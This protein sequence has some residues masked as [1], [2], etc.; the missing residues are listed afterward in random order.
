MLFRLHRCGPVAFK[1]VTS[2]SAMLC[3]LHRCGSVAF[4]SNRIVIFPSQSCHS[5]MLRMAKKLKLLLPS[6]TSIPTCLLRSIHASGTMERCSETGSEEAQP[7][8]AV[9]PPPP[10]AARKAGVV[11]GC[12]LRLQ[13]FGFPWIRHP[14][15]SSQIN[16]M[17]YDTSPSAVLLT[18]LP[19]ALGI[20]VT[21]ATV[22]AYQRGG[23]AV[24]ICF[25]TVAV[26]VLCRQKWESSLSGWDVLHVG[27]G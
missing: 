18:G 27:K 21:G 17:R 2:T 26:R 6:S 23:R 10:N 5:G 9:S 12:Q 15:P 13:S 3:R 8:T 7:S 24:S 14:L 20:K 4:K 22:S 19:G 16:C 1:S 11:P 25:V